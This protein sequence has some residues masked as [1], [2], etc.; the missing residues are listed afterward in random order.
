MLMAVLAD[1]RPAELF[2]FKN[3]HA[4]GIEHDSTVSLLQEFLPL[5][6]PEG[7]LK[8]TCLKD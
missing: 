5:P 7:Q 6:R 2:I 8:I 3:Y 4:P 1:R